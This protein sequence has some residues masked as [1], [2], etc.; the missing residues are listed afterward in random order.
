[1]IDELYPKTSWT[2]VYTDGS[3]TNAVENGGAGIYIMDPSGY[4]EEAPFPTGKHCT[5]YAAEVEALIHA[6]HII[7]TREENCSHV[8]FLTDALFALQALETN[9]LDRL[10]EALYPISSVN[11]VVLQW[12]SAHCGIPGNEN[13]DKLAKLGAAKEQE[14]NWVTYEVMESHIKSL[15]RPSKQTNDYYLLSRQEQV[16]IF[17]LRTGHNRLNQHMHKRFRLV[18]SSICSCGEA[19]QTTEHVIQ[20]CTNVQQLRETTWTTTTTL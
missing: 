18:P 19:E 15:N 6:A 4:R 1:M 17:R 9:K 2:Q 16:I 13:A 7:S 8:V 3:A 14:D 5:N 20:N 12:I 10:S 11:Q